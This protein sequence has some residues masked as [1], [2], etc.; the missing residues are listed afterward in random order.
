MRK[1]GWIAAGMALAVMVGGCGEKE[2]YVYTAEDRPEV[3][4]GMSSSRVGPPGMEINVSL[5]D[6]VAQ[7]ELTSDEIPVEYTLE[8]GIPYPCCYYEA[9][10]KD[11]WYGEAEET[12]IE[13]WFVGTGY[14]LHPNDQLV[15]Y[16]AYDGGKQYVPVDGTYSIFILNPP[17]DGIFPLSAN[18]V[19]EPLE[20]EDSSLLKQQTDEVFNRALEGDAGAWPG[21]AIFDPYKTEEAASE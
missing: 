9:E 18:S 15:M 1:L 5:S 2:R 13:L 3:S 14:N 17:D 4:A 21:G 6:I 16:A 8:P 11:V 19:F 7:I 20:G 10:I 12:D